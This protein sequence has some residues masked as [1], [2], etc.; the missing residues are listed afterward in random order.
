MEPIGAEALNAHSALRAR[1]LGCVLAERTGL[2]DLSDS[3]SLRPDLSR[4]VDYLRNKNKETTTPAGGRVII[5][6]NVRFA[7]RDRNGTRR[8]VIRI[9]SVANRVC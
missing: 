4:K 1:V 5:S 9:Y 8:A 2:I 3:L 7:K 6:R